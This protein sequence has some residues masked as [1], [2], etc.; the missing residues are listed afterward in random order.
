MS[1]YVYVYDSAITNVPFPTVFI[2]AFFCE[3]SI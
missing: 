2:G 1:L 3:V